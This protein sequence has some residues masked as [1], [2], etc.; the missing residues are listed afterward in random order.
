MTDLSDYENTENNLA[1]WNW[2]IYCPTKCSK[3]NSRI[4]CKKHVSIGNATN[5]VITE[6]V[7]TEENKDGN[8]DVILKK[9]FSQEKNELCIL[10]IFSAFI[11]K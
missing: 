5:K 6:I 10:L 8:E 9:E 7:K 4:L 1:R 2:S 11:M 3:N